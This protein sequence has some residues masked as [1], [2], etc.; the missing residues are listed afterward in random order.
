MFST[1]EDIEAPI[2]DV[3]H[4]FRTLISLSDLLCGAAQRCAELIR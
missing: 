2:V 1:K 4:G 3:S